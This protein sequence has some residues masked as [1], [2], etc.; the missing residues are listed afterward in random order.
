MFVLPLLLTIFIE[1]RL[2]LYF[3]CNFPQLLYLQ[4]YFQYGLE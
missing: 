4:Q 3:L 2:K 1:C